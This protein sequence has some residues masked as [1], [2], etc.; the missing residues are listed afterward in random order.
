MLSGSVNRRIYRLQRTE[1]IKRVNGFK[2]HHPYF[3]HIPD[4]L[5]CVR[6][7]LTLD[8]YLWK[9][10]TG[11]PRAVVYLAKPNVVP[12]KVGFNINPQYT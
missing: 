1:M 9:I 8:K 6:V 12:V 7:N 10:R 4:A 11:P 2:H 5:L 3:T